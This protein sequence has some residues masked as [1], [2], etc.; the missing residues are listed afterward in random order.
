MQ[1]NISEFFAVSV[2]LSSQG[3]CSGVLDSDKKLC[4]NKLFD[5]YTNMQAIITGVKLI[6]AIKLFLVTCCI[7]LNQCQSDLG[8]S[9]KLKLKFSFVNY[10]AENSYNS[11]FSA[12]IRFYRYI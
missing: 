8:H 7:N 1:S 10:R 5:I 9:Q 3:F 4:D 2:R 6:K 11:F 12:V